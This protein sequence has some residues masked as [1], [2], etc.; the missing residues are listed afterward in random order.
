[1]S[2]F[3][4]TGREARIELESWHNNAKTIRSDNA[5]VSIGLR[6]FYDFCLNSHSF[7]AGL[8]ETSGVDDDPFNAGCT[9]GIHCLQHFIRRSTDDRKIGCSGK[10]G[11][12]RITVNADD[13]FMIGIHR[14][15]D[16]FESSTHEIVQYLPAD[17]FWIR[18]HADQS[19]PFRIENLVQPVNIQNFLP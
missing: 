12:I 8:T 4:H 19:N 11:K 15:H 10:T 2:F 14:V 3:G 7:M 1:M 18:G 13:C 5:H 17:A 16:P 9:T 6:G